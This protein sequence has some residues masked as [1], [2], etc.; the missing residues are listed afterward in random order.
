MNNISEHKTLVER[1]D[2]S[3]KTA[4]G[5]E[6]LVRDRDLRFFFIFPIFFRRFSKYFVINGAAFLSVRIFVI[7]NANR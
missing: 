2:R 3:Q 7:I 1:T 4:F 6:K 5:E